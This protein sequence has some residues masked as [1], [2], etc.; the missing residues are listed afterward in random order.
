MLELIAGMKSEIE[1]DNENGTPEYFIFLL[2]VETTNFT[3][4]KIHIF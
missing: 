3:I 1:F 2:P 4:S